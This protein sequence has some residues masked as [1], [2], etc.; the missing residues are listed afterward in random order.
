MSGQPSFI[1]GTAGHIDHGKSALVC[2]LTGTDPDRLPEEKARGM[3]IDIGF[4]RLEIPGAGVFGIVDV[5]GHERFVR[6]MLAGATGI[7][8][9]L[10]VVASDDG[11]MPQT[12][13]HV[14]ILTLLGVRHAVVAL[15]KCDIAD[16][17][18]RARARAGIESLLAPTPLS[19]SAVVECSSKT[20]AGLSSLKAA[21]AAAARAI[22]SRAES[23]TLRL[24]IDRVFALEGIGAVVT[25]TCWGGRVRPGD[26]L[27]ILR[28]GH[29]R[30][31]LEA[32]EPLSVRVR[33][34]E[35]H[36]ESVASA[37]AGLRVAL[38]LAGA[39]KENLRRG[40]VVATPKTFEPV[41]LLEASF[42]C[43]AGAHKPLPGDFEAVI[44]HGT[45]EIP[46]RVRI[47]DRDEIRPGESGFAR[48]RLAGALAVVQGDPYVLR[49][50]SPPR[51]VG[52]G[53]ILGARPGARFPKAAGEAERLARLADASPVERMKDALRQA[54]EAGA[55]AVA[56]AA[57]TGRSRAQV[58]ADLCSLSAEGEAIPAGT[59]HLHASV[60]ARRAA[61][62]VSA[63]KEFHAKNP[64]LR[65]EPPA[66]LRRRLGIEGAVSE[67]AFAHALR[68]L[69]ARGELS[70]RDGRLSL[71]SHR[72]TLPSAVAACREPLLALLR[73]GLFAP[74]PAG[75][76]AARLG[77]PEA[78]LRATLAS[79]VDEGAVAKVSEDL[80]YPAAAITDIAG[81]VRAF[82]R[83]K[84]SMT[85]AQL[86]DLLGITRK[87]AVPIAEHLD[88]LRVTIRSGDLRVSGGG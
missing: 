14:E 60:A 87:H 52:G 86:R 46:A 33:S 38:N 7:D 39:K 58:D 27:E 17:A 66:E 64:L 9:A 22:P 31:T 24:P 32:S 77:R 73:A 59:V 3:T 8:L 61:E 67:A 1:L 10:L 75:E 55:T 5:P 72:P 34:V 51:T 43:V 15:T 12:R 16:E 85:V 81:K 69:V 49:L 48:I 57:W 20:G 83:T 76:W 35:V 63:L 62:I 80:C 82:L 50:A 70:E 25:G 37:S 13:E 47:L 28:T 42:V 36:G 2:A 79:L 11:V 71:A 30:T 88:R 44:Y 23:E 41:S 4:A 45:A 68:T 6:N 74:P 18:A 53:R 54:G 40:D 26:A 65:G 19:G 78:D 84:G 56:L 29:G 21:I